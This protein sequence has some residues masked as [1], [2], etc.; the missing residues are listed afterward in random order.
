MSE[1]GAQQTRRA[2]GRDSAFIHQRAG[3]CIIRDD[4]E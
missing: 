2:A 3:P 1:A 4:A